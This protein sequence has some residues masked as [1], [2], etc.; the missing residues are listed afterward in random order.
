MKIPKETFSE[1]VSEILY[2]HDPLNLVKFNVADDE[3]TD[4]AVAIILYLQY[5][6]DVRSLKWLVYE[7][8][9]KYFSQKRIAP[10]EDECY[11]C[12]AEEILDLWQD[13]IALAK[14][15]I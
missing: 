1:A 11:Q 9:V 8:F 5:V 10:V 12:I 7:V 15:S 6:S 2:H 14:Q 13:K 4:E 3:Y